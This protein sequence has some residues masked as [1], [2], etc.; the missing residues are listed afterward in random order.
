MIG[1][2]VG[3]V[4]ICNGNGMGVGGRWEGVGRVLGGHLRVV[5]PG[6]GLGV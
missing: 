2:S 1:A 3:W 6:L 5:R 4:W